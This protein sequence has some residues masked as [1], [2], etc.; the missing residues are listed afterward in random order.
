MGRKNAQ[1]ASGKVAQ[2]VATPAH[3]NPSPE[4]RGSGGVPSHQHTQYNRDESNQ[5]TPTLSLCLFYSVSPSS[6]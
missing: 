2:C 1:R 4:G 6:E 5:P 3:Q